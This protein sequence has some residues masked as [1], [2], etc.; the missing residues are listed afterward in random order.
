MLKALSKNLSIKTKLIVMVVMTIIAVSVIQIIQSTYNVKKMSGQMIEMYSANVYQEKEEELKNYVSMATHVVESYH[1]LSSKE[2]LKEE[3]DKLVTEQSNFLFSVIN[4]LYDKY[5]QS[6]SPEAL[7][8]LIK[9]TIAS[10][11]YGENGYFWVTNYDYQVVMHPLRPELDG[12]MF[13]NTDKNRFVT[14]AAD[15]LNQNNNKPSFISYESYNPKTEKRVLKTSIVRVFEPFGWIIGTGA[16]LDDVTSHLKQQAL[17]SLKHMSYGENGYFWVQN[18]NNKMVMHPTDPELEGEDISSLRDAHGKNHF[19]QMT[20]V[21]TNNIE[22]GLVKYMWPKPGLEN[23]VEK[24]SYVQMFEPWGWIIGT[25]TYV[26]DIA[27][28][29]KNIKENETKDIYAVVMQTIISSLVIIAV[30]ALIVTKLSD[31]L[32]RYPL[33]SFKEG[34][35]GFFRYINHESKEV[36]A[37]DDTQNDEIGTIATIVNQNIERTQ[38]HIAQ[39]TLLIDDV[40]RCVQKVKEGQVDQ[41]VNGT[42]HNPQ[43][44]NLKQLFN[45]MLSSIVENVGQDLTKLQKA[46]EHYHRYDFTYRITADRGEELVGKISNGLND[47]SNMIS[48][49]LKHNSQNGETLK[50]D[51]D[52]LADNVKKLLSQTHKQMQTV[53]NVTNE[54]QLINEH[55]IGNVE[56]SAQVSAQADDI[57]N[58]LAIISDIAD[59]TNLLALNA[60]I[61]SARAGEHGRG[62]AVVADEVRKLAEKT[63][64]SLLEIEANVNLLTASM[65]E[66]ER[67]V[68]DQSKSMVQINHSMEEINEAI[69]QVEASANHTNSVSDELAK[70][71]QKIY[72]DISS[73]KF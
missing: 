11:R 33:E 38:K 28:N 72:E 63:Q 58:V 14:L 9:D 35:L 59:Q 4:D 57:K 32:I 22:G 29:V 71:S 36:K 68:Q 31:I 43:L 7:K 73:K 41:H 15:T 49:M 2:R 1:K 45:E 46:F 55:M 48:E 65:H 51:S 47:L 12:Q 40:S 16:Y 6:I 26:D 5:H 20:T 42:S 53:S 27:L 25:G 3:A 66:V 44:E 37:L 21:A 19:A 39:D 17:E 62:F 70:A 64:K 18:S 8:R 56:K 52:K 60:A 30:L 50:T 13:H 61:E 69:E 10:A 34:M 54:I 24:F 67:S 23:P